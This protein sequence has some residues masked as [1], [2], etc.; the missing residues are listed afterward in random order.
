MKRSRLTLLICCLFGICTLSGCTVGPD[1]VKP[2]INTAP[3]YKSDGLWQLAKPADEYPKGAW[4]KVFKDET[5]NQL[6]Q[7]HDRLNLTVA[8]AEAQYRQAS[9]LL[10]QAQ[11]SLFPSVDLDASRTRGVLNSGSTSV[12]D[13]NTITGS[14][15]WE[16]DLWGGIRR[17]V[18]ASQAALEAS[19][20]QLEA[21]K[22]SSQAQLATA[23]FTLRITDAQIRCLS[24]SENLLLKAWELTRNQYRAGIISQAQLSAAQGQYKIARAARVNAQLARAQL[25]HA[26]AVCVGQIPGTFTLKANTHKV[27]IPHIPAGL[28]SQLLERRPDIAAAERK[29]AQ[30]NAQIGVAKAAYF[31]SL[32]LSGSGGWQNNSLGH[33]FTVPHRIWAIGPALALNLF[34]AGLRRAKTEQAIAIYDETVAAYRQKVLTSFAEVEDYLTSQALLDE[35]Y[36]LQADAVNATRTSEKITMNQ[37]RSGVVGY[38]DVIVSQNNRIA[39][40]NTLYDIKKRQ[41]TD[42]VALIVAIGGQW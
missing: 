40:E 1:Y 15:S 14:I 22:L 37:Y 16:V 20:A 25:E 34:D 13:K 39:S 4:W 31:P 28:P 27:Y 32:T 26:I 11:A 8:Q 17:Q 19:K 24:E 33:L 38:L 21:I 7:K 5:L 18:E 6:M 42:R 9:A 41:L 30:T 35:Q 36:K 23:Y 29:V 2:D 3:T 10:K 12:V